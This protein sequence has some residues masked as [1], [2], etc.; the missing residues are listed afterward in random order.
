MTVKQKTGRTVVSKVS[1]VFLR[2]AV[3]ALG[4]VALLFGGLILSEI[5]RNFDDA[6]P[7]IGFLRYPIVLLLGAAFIPF[8]G[9]LYQAMKLL[10][11]I[12]TNQAFSMLAVD[13]LRKIKHCAFMVGGLFVLLLPLAFV[14][15]EL[16]DAPGLIII[17][18]AIA[19]TP[20]AIAVFAALL[21]KLLESAIAIKNENDLTV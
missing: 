8:V 19:G 7:S 9:A 6:F 1:T 17:V 2:A 10:R 4:L 21:E 20:L 5:Y 16:D 18:T 3:V 13:A 11:Y 12:D 14:V 15:A